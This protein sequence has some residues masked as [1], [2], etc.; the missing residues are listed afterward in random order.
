M[1]ELSRNYIQENHYQDINSK[2]SNHEQNVNSKSKKQLSTILN[3]TTII[4]ELNSK[5]YIKFIL[6][7]IKSN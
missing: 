1:L 4:Q 6:N 7:T 3:L 5:Q 2:I